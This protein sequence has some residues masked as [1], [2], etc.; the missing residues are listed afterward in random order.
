M[1]SHVT[2]IE[3]KKK[4]NT[5][6]TTTTTPPVI[7]KVTDFHS[8]DGRAYADIYTYLDRLETRMFDSLLLSL[9]KFFDTDRVTLIMNSRKKASSLMTALI[10]F[11]VKVPE[12]YEVVR[13]EGLLALTDL[14]QNLCKT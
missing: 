8:M 5:S 2:T 12:F 3:Q 14:L 7:M 9:R 6:T 11:D 10:D 4:I 13:A 1:S